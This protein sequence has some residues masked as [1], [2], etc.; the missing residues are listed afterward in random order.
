MKKCL[1]L[2][3]IFIIE[4]II[5]IPLLFGYTYAEETQH[6]YVKSTANLEI[7]EEGLSGTIEIKSS[8]Y[9]EATTE[10]SADANYK[11]VRYHGVKGR[12][13][14]SALSQKTCVP[15]GSPYYNAGAAM[16]LQSTIDALP[17]Q[18]I[19]YDNIVNMH[20]LGTIEI[21]EQLTFIAPAIGKDNKRFYLAMKTDGTKLFVAAENS[22]TQ[23]SVPENINAINPDNTSSELPNPDAGK[24]SDAKTPTNN[25]LRVLLITVVCILAVLVIF[26]IFKPTKGGKKRKRKDYYDDDLDDRR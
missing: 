2:M 10:V 18:V 15:T 8:W 1:R 13:A 5:L 6:Y 25:L 9:V 11:V 22:V 17:T 3:S 16:G 26:L 7:T 14:T 12:I 19:V 23:Y 21:S 24:D 4:A 20:S